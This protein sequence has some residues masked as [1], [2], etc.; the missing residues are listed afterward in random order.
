MSVSS[1]KNACFNVHSLLHTLKVYSRLS[2]TLEHCEG[3]FC[4][5]SERRPDTFSA[6]KRDVTMLSVIEYGTEYINKVIPAQADRA[7]FPCCEAAPVHLNNPSL[8]L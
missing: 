1:D 2:D 6:L 3:F 7:H 4:G 5:T 8:Y